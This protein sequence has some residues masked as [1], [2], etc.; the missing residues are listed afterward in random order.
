M[1]LRRIVFVLGFF[2]AVAGAAWSDSAMMSVQ[3]KE[4]QLRSTPSFLGSIVGPV[5]Y[6]DRVETMQKQGDW[7]DVKSP[8]NLRGWIHQS[9]LTSKQVVL[10]PG[11][12]TQSAASGQ[13]IALAGKGFNSDVEAQYRKK[14]AKI[15]Y[16]WVNRME[17]FVVSRNQMISFLDEGKVKP[18]EGGKK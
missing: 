16:T 4:A 13:E 11:A 14:N 10:N 5:S 2:L 9:A 18:S 12:Q 8:K 1:K 17:T 7:I 6:G 3:V 15:D